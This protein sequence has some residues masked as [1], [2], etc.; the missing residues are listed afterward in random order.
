MKV[1][2]LICSSLILVYLKPSY[3]FFFIL[4]FFIEYFYIIY[5]FSLF[6][7]NKNSNKYNLITIDKYKYCEK[8]SLELWLEINKI[9]AFLKL[10]IF[11]QK[12]KISTYSI[13]SMLI[14]I[15]LQIPLRIIILTKKLLYCKGRNLKERL[16]I[17]YDLSYDSSKNLK[18][19]IMNKNIYLNCFTLRELV[20]N[21]IK[22]NPKIKSNECYKLID[23]LKTHSIGYNK[24]EL[25]SKDRVQT[26]MSK[27]I[28]KESY[29]IPF[30]HPT[31]IWD[32][33]MNKFRYN[34]ENTIMTIHGTSNVEISVTSTQYIGS[35]INDFIKKNAIKPGS[36]VTLEPK[37][38]K[39]SKFKN[40]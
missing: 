21:I 20:C 38:H 2:I 40:I 11:T 4:F 31:Y 18:I 7:K 30:M 15:L 28:T 25:S 33:K 34:Q 35:P 27:I 14:V 39:V 1:I 3:G 19:E 36:I 23:L 37:I 5:Y 17:I 13:I 32:L 6:I 22:M 9:N 12:K 24:F 10:Y 26:Y 16:L 29:E 8:S